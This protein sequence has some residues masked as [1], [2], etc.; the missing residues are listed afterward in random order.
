MA[1]V[2]SVRRA[3]AVV[4]LGEH[5]NVVT[6]P[7]GVLEDGGGA[8]VD[9]GVVARGLIRRGTVKIPD[10]ELADVGNFLIRS[11]GKIGSYGPEAIARSD[12]ERFTMVFDRRPP[13]PSI[14]TSGDSLVQCR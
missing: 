10:T 1:V 5:K 2:R 8:E 6:A 13:S 9:V 4:R 7:E 14:Q 11:L 3:I 12:E